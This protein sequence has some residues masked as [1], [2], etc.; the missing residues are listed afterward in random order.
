M[1]AARRNTEILGAVDLGS[2][3][4]HMVIGR[5]AHGQLTVMDRLREP[6]RLAAGLDPQQRLDKNS[7]QRAL[8]CLARFGERLRNMRASRVRVV[9]TN[10][11]RKA[12]ATEGFL[13]HAARV[14][15]HRVEVIAGIEEARLIYLGVSHSLPK[16]T[17][18]NW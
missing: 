8:E 12:R 6:V 9:G 15:G 10:T 5:F 17:A 18:P 7:E 16:S 11:L 1:A 14:L 13:R 3:S 2:N 4:F